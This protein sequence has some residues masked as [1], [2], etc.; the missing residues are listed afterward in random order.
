MAGSLGRVDV[1]I[2]AELLAGFD[3]VFLACLSSAGVEVGTDCEEEEELPIRAGCG[4]NIVGFCYFI[5]EI[6]SLK[7]NIHQQMIIIS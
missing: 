4:W 7:Y 5:V 6:F 1:A 3:G 2:C